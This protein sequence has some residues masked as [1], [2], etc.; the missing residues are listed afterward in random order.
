MTLNDDYSI[1]VVEVSIQTDK[2]YDQGA[3]IL[4][5]GAP[6]EAGRCHNSFPAG[7]SLHLEI[8]NTSVINV[9]HW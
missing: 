2:A 3:C 4:T 5:I 9:S 8:E 6:S 1:T 7:N